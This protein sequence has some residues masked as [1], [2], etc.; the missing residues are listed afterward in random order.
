MPLIAKASVTVSRFSK[1]AADIINTNVNGEKGK[2]GYV[3]TFHDAIQPTLAPGNHLD[4]MNR[5]MLGAIATS[6]NQTKLECPKQTQLFDWVK[7]QITL[8]TTDAAYGPSNPYR[9]P[10]LADS[11]WY[12]VIALNISLI[13][14]NSNR[15]FKAGM[16]NLILGMQSTTSAKDAIKSMEFGAKTFEEYY[17]QGHHLSGSA[18]TQARFNHSSEHHIPRNDIAR[19]EFSNGV[20]LLS[21]T[22]PNSFW[23]LYHVYSDAELLDACRKE[24]SDVVVTST[25]QDSRT[26]HIVDMT[27]VK[28]SCPTLFSIYKEVLRFYSTAVSARMVMEDYLLD[29]TYLLKKGSTIMM[30]TPVQHRDATMWSTDKDSFDH[31][32]FLSSD[33]RLSHAGFRAFG[34]GTTLCPGRH[35]ATTEILAFV[36]VMILQFDMEPESGVWPQL[37]HSKVDFWE[38]T[39]SP[40]VDFEVEIRARKHGLPDGEWTFTLS[41]SDQPLLLSAEDGAPAGP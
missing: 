14:I 13:P 33:S 25:Q 34:G 20:A 18:L 8:A 29:D 24:V 12:E 6:L 35:F 21:N 36:T 30:P 15:T 11:F 10:E 1:V 26:T 9:K 23:L 31:R 22:V 3:M 32:R 28:Q 39:P 16:S 17:N 19:S 27:K 40:D 4:S 37:S 5:V 7:A 2:W 38:S 41:D